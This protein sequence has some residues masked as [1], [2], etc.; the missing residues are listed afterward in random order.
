VLKVQ[1]RGLFRIVK[2]GHFLTTVADG[3]RRRIL[4]LISRLGRGNRISGCIGV[5]TC[6]CESIRCARG[7]SGDLIAGC[8]EFFTAIHGEIRDT[9]LRLVFVVLLGN[10]SVMA[11]GNSINSIRQA[12]VRR[13][14]CPRIYFFSRD[15]WCSGRGYTD[16]AVFTVRP[17]FSDQAPR[18]F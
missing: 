6:V 10:L 7:L 4:P 5:C 8:D 1:A 18:V 14:L 17:C 12:T 9:S 3:G 11:F 2:S 15:I 16:Q 13:Y